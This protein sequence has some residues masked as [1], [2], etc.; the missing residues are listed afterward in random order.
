MA[1]HAQQQILDAVK[2]ALVAAATDAAAR[3]HIDRVDEYTE[4]DLPAI[5]ITAGDEPVEPLA[6]HIRA[7]QRREMELEIACVTAGAS[8][9]ADARELAKQVEQALY[10][11][12]SVNT[13]SGKCSALT[14]TNVSPQLVAG[15]SVLMAEVRHTWRA[16]Y[17]VRAGVPDTPV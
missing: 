7:A 2:A 11:T 17:H 8:A 12:V 9:M 10:A 5:R 13:L 1:A 14:L 4:A 16:T 6:L 3:V 15:A